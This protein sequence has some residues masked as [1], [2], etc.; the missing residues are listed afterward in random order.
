[1]YADKNRFGLATITMLS[2]PSNNEAV[3]FQQH[4]IRRVCS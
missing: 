4:C 2:N 3:A 1:M